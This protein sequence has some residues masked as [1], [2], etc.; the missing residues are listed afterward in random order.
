[1]LVPLLHTTGTGVSLIAV[2]ILSIVTINCH[3]ACDVDIEM[4]VGHDGLQ[5]RYMNSPPAHFNGTSSDLD[6]HDLI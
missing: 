6:H 2:D 3:L 5:Q 1:M 4:L